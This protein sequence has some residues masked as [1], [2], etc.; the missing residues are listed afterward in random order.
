[1]PDR[2]DRCDYT[3]VQSDP[4]SAKGAMSR[5]T[6]PEERQ[7]AQLCQ[8]LADLRL[9]LGLQ[10]RLVQALLS[11]AMVADKDVGD[12]T[13]FR[14]L[15]AVADGMLPDFAS[16]RERSV[17]E[18]RSDQR[19]YRRTRAADHAAVVFFVACGSRG[20]GCLRAGHQAWP[21]TAFARVGGKARTGAR[22]PPRRHRRLGTL[23][24]IRSSLALGEVPAVRLNGTARLFW[25]DMLGLQGQLR[26]CEVTTDFQSSHASN[27]DTEWAYSR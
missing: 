26:V 20:S 13:V 23:R 24:N 19:R 8:S 7:A 9:P 4:T 27:Q 11:A 15:E 1:M 25:R 6:A 17:G 3:G 12:A 18:P 14:V 10:R 5:L 16:C 21:L 2:I 22:T